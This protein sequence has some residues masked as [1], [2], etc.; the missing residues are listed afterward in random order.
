MEAAQYK[1][2]SATKELFIA[3]IYFNPHTT[4]H[5][6]IACWFLFFTSPLDLVRFFYHQYKGL[7]S[8]DSQF[9]PVECL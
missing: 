4:D 9:I 1:L 8:S 2:W 6:C 3:L 7:L 5:Q